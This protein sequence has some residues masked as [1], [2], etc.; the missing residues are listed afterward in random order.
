LPAALSTV[1]RDAIE[2]L[3]SPLL[4]RV[5]QCAGTPCTLVFLDA[6]RPGKRRWCSMDDCGNREKAAGLRTKRRAGKTGGR[7]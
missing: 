7:Q 5:R 6:S 3:S 4:A 1:A 2:L